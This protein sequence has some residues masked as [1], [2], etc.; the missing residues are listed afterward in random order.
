MG[1]GS[2]RLPMML[3]LHRLIQKRKDGPTT[4]MPTL[5]ENLQGNSEKC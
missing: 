4:E 1:K 3:I 2:G 5:T